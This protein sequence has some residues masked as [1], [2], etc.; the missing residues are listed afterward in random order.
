MNL[1]LNA[2]QAMSGGGELQVSTQVLPGLDGQGE[3]AKRRVEIRFQDSG[4]GIKP[5][6][7]PK[8]FEPYFTTKEVGIGL[9]LALT[10]QITEEH[11]GRI[12]ISSEPGRGTLVRLQLPVG[13]PNV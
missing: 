13:A 8:V 9:G 3:E 5:E 2:F 1:V 7:L 6:D 10:K 4:T 11:G 12:E